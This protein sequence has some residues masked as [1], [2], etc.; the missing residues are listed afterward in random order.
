ME[1]N[2]KM[3]WGRREDNE[4]GWWGLFV[5]LIV[6]VICFILKVMEM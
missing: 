4:I 6:M 1:E 2:R 3:R 5:V